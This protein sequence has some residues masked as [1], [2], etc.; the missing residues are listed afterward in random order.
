MKRM[1]RLAVLWALVLL[2]SGCGGQ[3]PSVSGQEREGNLASGAMG[4]Y[5]ETLYAFPEEVNRNGGLNWLDD[6]SLSVISYGAGLYRS[7]DEG[8]T[9]Q[10]E[11]TS[12]YPLIENVYC[13]SAVM[14]PDG[15]VAATCSGQMSEAVRTVY[16]KSVAEDWEGN[17]CVFALP[18]GSVKVVDFGFSQEDGNCLSSF[19]F[20]ED[21]RLFAADISGRMYEVDVEKESLKELFVAEH[22]LGYL[23][24]SQE[25]LMAVGDDRL[26]LYDLEQEVLLPQ[27]ETVDTFI[28]QKILDG[29]V[30]YTSG[31]YPLAVMGS[32]EEDV[33]YLAC[34]D[35]MYRHVLH[36]SVM[37]QVIDGALS[38][39]GDSYISIYRM[40]ALENQEFLAAFGPSVGVARYN[41]DEE[42]PSMPDREIRIYSLREDKGVRQAVTAYKKEHTDLYVRYEV[43]IDSDSSTTT[44]DAIKRLNT[45]ILAGD[46]PDV[47][48]LDGLPAAAYQ[49]NGMLKDIRTVFESMDGEEVL[50]ENVVDSFT[51]ADGAIYQMPLEVRVPLLVGEKE[52]ITRAQDLES[53]AAEM[54]QI[55]A[56]SPEGGIFGIYD[57]EAFLRL[58]GMVSSPAWL[59]EEG[60]M[61]VEAVSAFLTLVQ[62]MYDLELSGAIAEQRETIKQ[63][64]AEMASY[65]IDVSKQCTLAADNVL[66][67]SEGYASLAAGAV[68]GIQ[69][70]LDTVTSVIRVQEGLD[71][72]LFQG[73]GERLFLPV[74][75]V[76]ISAR[77]TQP[78][79]AEEFI[80]QMFCA[81]TQEDLYDGFPVNREAYDRRF[82]FFEEGNSNGTMTLQKADGTE[83]ELE[84]YWPNQEERAQFTA[85]MESI[86]VPVLTEENLCELVYEE[87]VKV[88]EG[89]KSVEDAAA[90]IVKKSAIYLAE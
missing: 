50:F 33:I 74:A 69:L 13:L 24:F 45:Q 55:R 65:G 1:R 43:G 54:E 85:C 73:Q 32:S 68:E 29:T 77:T 75:M 70:D 71:Y 5:M 41:F 51:E 49:E 3:S 60:Q 4:R 20:K 18:D 44:E 15:T 11:E 79:E 82:V 67:V 28:R 30:S 16:G 63:Q 2:V 48:V 8:K 53:L 36:G 52:M 10:A 47:L 23:D 21:G 80:C 7:L 78:E 57:P 83:Q 87:G 26:Y 27:D 42:V 34:N 9:W 86:A 22:S 72:C 38:S 40:K 35:G 25:I 56:A 84:L 88:L 37:E 39:F 31:G 46:G 81:D 58:F 14:G 64:D 59:D 12:W 62:R 76:G 66:Y 17:Y 6:G 19:V 89:E 90:E 61:D